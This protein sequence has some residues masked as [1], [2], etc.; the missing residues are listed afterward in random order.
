[1]PDI[2]LARAIHV[3]SIVLW[4]GGVGF[5]TI[6][7]LPILKNRF[8]PLQQESIFHA[9]ESRF[10]ALAKVL[11]LLAGL[12]GF[13]MTYRLGLWYRFDE[14]KFAWMHAMVIVW[15]I[16]VFALFIVEPLML[17]RSTQQQ[18]TAKITKNFNRVQTMHWVLLIVSII[19][20]AASVLGS[21][22]FFY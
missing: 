20:V 2:I 5:V 12:S 3:I 6:I 1:M 7:A 19:T 22:G 21:H 14:L 8:Q 11:V 10:A 15:L 17:Y 16:F 9:L 13:Y 18:D 4:I